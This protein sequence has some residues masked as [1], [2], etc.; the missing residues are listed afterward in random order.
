M[1]YVYHIVVPPSVSLRLTTVKW[2]TGMM[3][4][5]LLLTCGLSGIQ[6]HYALH[7][8]LEEDVPPVLGMLLETIQGGL[9]WMHLLTVGAPLTATWTKSALCSPLGFSSAFCG[10]VQHMDAP[11]RSCKQAVIVDNSA[12]LSGSTFLP[13]TALPKINVLQ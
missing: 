4:L 6:R 11:S 5:S 1:Q 13:S 3:G 7:A 8:P 12:S 9:I 2:H 10:C